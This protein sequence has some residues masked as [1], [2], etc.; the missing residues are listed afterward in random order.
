[1]KKLTTVIIALCLCVLAEAQTQHVVR[2]GETPKNIADKYN[3]TV[4]QL[5]E[6]NPAARGQIHVGIPLTIP[7]QQAVSET[8]A[9]PE[10][11]AV[12]ETRPVTE[13]KPVAE[14]KDTKPVT[15]KPVVETKETRPVSESVS[16]EPSNKNVS[17]DANYALLS[18][19][20]DNTVKNIVYPQQADRTISDHV[21]GSSGF[22]WIPKSENRGFTYGL[23]MSMGYRGFLDIAD[24]LYLTNV[25]ALAGGWTACHTKN[26]TDSENYTNTY[27]S[28]W[29]AG[30]LLPVQLN[31]K[32]N[33]NVVFGVGGYIQYYLLGKSETE[34]NSMIYGIRIENK[35]TVKMWDEDVNRLTYGLAFNIYFDNP[36]FADD[37]GLQYRL[38]FYKDCPTPTHFIS[39]IL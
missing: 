10:T 17:A 39:I 35:N 11:P 18:Q 14:A 30:L 25:I 32:T 2:R 37:M 26:K 12:V 29:Y 22:Q 27:N 7:S 38:Q 3:I 31:I 20:K 9:D 24:N 33:E 8:P 36:G 21:Y 16:I 1:M 19:N 5:F 6:A 15:A 13:T 4:E 23:D 34:T 28:N